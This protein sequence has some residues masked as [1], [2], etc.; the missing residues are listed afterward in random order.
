MTEAR[1]TTP[2]R[3]AFAVRPFIS[4]MVKPSSLGR[5][6]WRGRPPPGRGASVVGFG[7]GDLA[8]GFTPVLADQ[9]RGIVVLLGC[10]WRPLGRGLRFL[11]RAEAC[12]GLSRVRATRLEAARLELLQ[13]RRP[14]QHLVELSEWWGLAFTVATTHGIVR[15]ELLH[16]GARSRLAGRSEGS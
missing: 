8:L 13:H 6:E 4:S 15:V 9:G 11:L 12:L 5:Q 10:P 1:L 14:R 3:Q 7:R 16:A 2:C